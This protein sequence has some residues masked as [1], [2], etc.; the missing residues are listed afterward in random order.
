MGIWN[1]IEQ[2][3]WTGDVVKDYGTISEAESGPGNRKVSVVLAGKGAPRIFVR[4]SYRSWFAGSV[5]FIELDRDTA[6]KLRAAID[7]ALPQM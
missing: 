2:R 1:R 7:D 4:V 3:L 5:A 6:I